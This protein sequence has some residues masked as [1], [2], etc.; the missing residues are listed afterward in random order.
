MCNSLSRP[1]KKDLEH[2]IRQPLGRGCK[3]FFLGGGSPYKRPGINTVSGEGS[4]RDCRDDSADSEHTSAGC[5]IAC[6]TSL[7]P[8]ITRQYYYTHAHT[9]A[10]THTHTFNGS[11]SGTTRVSRYQKG[12]RSIA[13]LSPRDRAMRRVN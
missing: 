4:R 12:T 10:H 7:D 9:H 8:E 13:Q 2:I 6:E 11:L 5:Y 3:F 1:K